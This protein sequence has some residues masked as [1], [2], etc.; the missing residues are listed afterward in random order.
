LH[1]FFLPVLIFLIGVIPV[2]AQLVEEVMI[3]ISNN[4]SVLVQEK[5]NPLSTISSIGIKSISPNINSIIATDENNVILK[6]YLQGDIIK[7]DTLGASKVNLQY[8]ADV[9]T[10]TNDVWT[11]D[12]DS[13]APSS[14]ILPPSASIV[15]LS[16]IP[17]SII[18]NQLLIPAGQVSIS[19]TLN[20]VTKYVFEIQKQNQK[21]E[22]QIMTTSK[23]SNFEYVHDKMSFDISDKS[24]ILMLIPSSLNYQYTAQVDGDSLDLKQQHQDVAHVWIRIDPQKKGTITIYENQEYTKTSS[25]TEEKGGGCLIATATYGSELTPQVQQLRELRDNSLLQT[26]S[27]TSFMTGFNQFYY[28]FSPTVADWERE[29]PAFKEFIKITLI[30]MISSLSILNYVDMDSESSVLGYGISL[31]LL[32]VGMYFVMPAFIILRLKSKLC[33]IMN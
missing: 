21:S 8:F 3:K 7:I 15:S 6:S 18:D 24:P 2:H 9:I 17:T 33:R 25:E 26:E 14:V 4:G 16:N 19:Y 12:Y 22:I 20:P 28:S 1:F 27:G 30:P 32:N 31:I 5:L 29:N 13:D 11:I 10:K 23:V